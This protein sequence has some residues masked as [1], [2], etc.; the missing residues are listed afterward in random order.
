[1]LAKSRSSRLILVITIMIVL[2][3][4][5]KKKKEIERSEFF[6]RDNLRDGYGERGHGA[7]L[8]LD[9]TL[10]HTYVVLG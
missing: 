8:N 2:E 7:L 1:M 6:F 3:W 9:P 10:A 4:K 5:L